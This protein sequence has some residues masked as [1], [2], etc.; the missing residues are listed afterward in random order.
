MYV[1]MSK[2][3]FSKSYYTLAIKNKKGKMSTRLQQMTSNYRYK[4]EF[5]MIHIHPKSDMPSVL[6]PAAKMWA[7]FLFAFIC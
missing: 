5:Q 6:V 4:V 3:R 7:A 2:K 1:T